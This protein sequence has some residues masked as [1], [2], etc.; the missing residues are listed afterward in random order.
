MNFLLL[1]KISNTPVLFFFF[2]AGYIDLPHLV[3]IL[4]FQIGTFLCL[5]F[6]LL[7]FFY[8]NSIAIILGMNDL[9]LGFVR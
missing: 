4:G 3:V 5:L 8:Y 9:N 6:F 2:G 1:C 7:F